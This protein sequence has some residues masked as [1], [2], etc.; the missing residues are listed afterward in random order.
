MDGSL[1]HD[2]PGKRLSRLYGVNHFIASQVNP[3]VTPFVSEK[4]KAKTTMQMVAETSSKATKNIVSNILKYTT[5]NLSA[6][7]LSY[8][9][10]QIH[11]MVAQDYSADITI[12]PNFNTLKP[13]K[14]F[15]NPEAS[16]IEALVKAGEQATWPKIEWIRNCTKISR[17][18]DSIIDS[19]EEAPA[20]KRKL[21]KRK[22]CQPSV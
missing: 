16:D 15:N 21:K 7:S 13:W 19:L 18:L 22:F 3:H 20:A 10:T 12:T 17:T 4:G 2:L 14:L 8:A 11:A 9:L 1:S 5:D 6:P